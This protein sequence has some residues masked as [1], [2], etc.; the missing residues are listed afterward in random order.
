MTAVPTTR[1]VVF[2]AIALVGCAVDLGTKHWIFAKMRVPAAGTDWIWDEVFGFTTH[3]NEGALFGFGQGQVVLFVCLSVVAAIGILYWLFWLG[4][5]AD[6]M[7]TVALGCVTAGI[8][9]NLY[10]RL[11]LPGL[12]WQG[13]R[14]HAD[15][16]AVFAVRDWI[17]FKWDPI[18]DWP[19]FNIADSML[20]LGSGLLVWYAFRADSAT[21]RE[22]HREKALSQ[23]P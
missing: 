5:A 2:F 3:L 21:H 7:L 22:P 20:V 15:G 4:A 11:G 16:E 14:V 17:H 23:A 12:H 10:D 13:H 18:I 19:I 6:L 1:Y 9:G 8:L